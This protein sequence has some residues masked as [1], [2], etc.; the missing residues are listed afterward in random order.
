MARPIT[1]AQWDEFRRDIESVLK[2]FLSRTSVPMASWGVVGTAGD[3]FLEE[4]AKQLAASTVAVAPIQPPEKKATKRPER[5]EPEA[6]EAEEPAEEESAPEG[7]R[8]LCVEIV[9][10]HGE[11]MRV[12]EVR[13]A[14]ARRGTDLTAKQVSTVL[15][16]AAA[17]GELRA[18]KEGNKNYLYSA[19][20]GDEAVDP[21]S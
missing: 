4:V 15:Q 20:E 10:E 5:E 2:R 16:R 11:E 19:V 14:A 3:R 7:R 21:M 13:E 6:D 17:A 1:P 12:Y 9:R 18:R 8:A